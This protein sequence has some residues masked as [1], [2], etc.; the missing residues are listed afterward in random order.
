[1]QENHSHLRIQTVVILQQEIIT[2]SPVSRMEAFPLLQE[3][4][5]QSTECQHTLKKTFWPYVLG[6]SAFCFFQK[7]GI[8]LIQVSDHNYSKDAF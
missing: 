1:M 2:T 5:T 6:Q 7:R 8:F 4:N 3:V